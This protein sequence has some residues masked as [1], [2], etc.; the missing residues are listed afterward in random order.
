M[1]VNDH[2]K[3]FIDPFRFPRN[4]GLAATSQLVRVSRTWVTADEHTCSIHRNDLRS[5]HAEMGA[6]FVEGGR[7]LHVEVR[8]DPSGDSARNSGHRHL[9]HS[10]GWMT[11]TAGTMGRTATG[12]CGRLL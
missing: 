5:L 6:S 7:P 11:R 2:W 12:L 10:L 9:F 1:V 8:V 3:C 4:C